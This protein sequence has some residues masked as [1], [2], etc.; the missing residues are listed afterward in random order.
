[1]A[2]RNPE[3]RAFFKSRLGRI[4]SHY[5]PS[6]VKE[7]MVDEEYC[8]ISCPCCGHVSHVGAS[9]EQLADRLKEDNGF[10][11]YFCFNTGNKVTDDSQVAATIYQ[12]KQNI[13]ALIEA[14]GL[15]S[16]FYRTLSSYKDAVKPHWFDYVDMEAVGDSDYKIMLSLPFEDKV[17]RLSLRQWR[18]RLNSKIRQSHGTFSLDENTSRGIKA[19]EHLSRLRQ[20][21]PYGQI[22]TLHP[23]RSLSVMHCGKV[24]HIGEFT[25]E[26][27]DFVM[28]VAKLQRRIDEGKGKACFCLICAH[29]GG[30]KAPST[31]K[32]IDLANQ[33]WTYYAAKVATVLGDTDI[34]GISVSSDS[35]TEEPL[36]TTKDKLR[37]QCHNPDHAPIVDTYANRLNSKRSGYCKACL[38]EAGV[39]HIAELEEK[40]RL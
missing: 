23:S 36:N 24:S 21:Y 30:Y 31:P 20:V 25:V 12:N 28:D 13:I 16:S 17:H 22:K 4:Y 33:L 10:L 6:S 39:K 11:C 2:W 15:V 19:D 26:H 35:N 27:P 1:M 32:T 29:E 38:K 18:V 8:G 3:K 5:I 37:F 7:D 14:T 9:K 34:A 40:H